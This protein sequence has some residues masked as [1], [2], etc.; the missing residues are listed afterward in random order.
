YSQP[1]PEPTFA[2]R[3]PYEP[4]PV[5][6]PIEVEQTSINSAPKPTM[7]NMAASFPP[8]D[9]ADEE[10]PYEMPAFLRNK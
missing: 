10:D 5:A 9:Y 4:I 2:P 8:T 7:N 1:E 6:R 3:A